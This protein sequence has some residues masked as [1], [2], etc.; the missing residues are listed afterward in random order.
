MVWALYTLAEGVWNYDTEKNTEITLKNIYK[1]NNID[2]HTEIF[3]FV[4]QG[5]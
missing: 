2:N 1:G 5:H 4:V 3:V